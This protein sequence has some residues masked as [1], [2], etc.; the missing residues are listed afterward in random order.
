MPR[1]IFLAIALTLAASPAFSQSPNDSTAQSPA[2]FQAD[3]CTEP[4]IEE[5][6]TDTLPAK[7]QKFLNYLG[8]KQQSHF[9]FGGFNLGFVSAI[10]APAAM[11]LDMSSS[12]EVSFE[13]LAYRWYFRSKKQ[14]FTVGVSFG[15][16]NF[17]MTGRTRFAKDEAG[18]L[19]FAPYPDEAS[20]I[21]SSRIKLFSIGLPFRYGFKLGQH[22]SADL[23]A[24][25]N[26]NTFASI[27]SR[28]KVPDTEMI[29]GETVVHRVKES[30]THIHQKKVSVDFMAQVH[31]R[32]LGVYAKY[33]PCKVLNPEFGPSFTPLSVGISLFY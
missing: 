9:K 4:G 29:P 1:N 19:S 20:K 12:I 25:L 31:W 5:A 26:F 16:R 13:P 27:E 6:R 22:W 30:D 21:E 17:R 3:A 33:S 15:W 28:Y 7:A 18:N 2:V 24:I 14:H 11:S 32:F 8:G 10:D 23:A